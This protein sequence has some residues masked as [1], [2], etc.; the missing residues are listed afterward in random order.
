MN[1]LSKSIFPCLQPKKLNNKF[2]Q[3]SLTQ[4]ELR[5]LGC[6]LIRPLAWAYFQPPLPVESDEESEVDDE[7]RVQRKEAR[8]IHFKILQNAV[9][10]TVGVSTIGAFLGE[11]PSGDNNPLGRSIEILQHMA[12]MPGKTCED[13]MDVM[14]CMIARNN[15]SDYV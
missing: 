14:Q 8:R 9:E 15:G 12:T 13:A 10:C 2:K 3:Q 4:E 11:E 1:Q 7:I 5:S 6:L